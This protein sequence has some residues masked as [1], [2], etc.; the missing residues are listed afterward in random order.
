[1]NIERMYPSGGWLVTWFD[2]E[3]YLVRRR[4]YDYTKGEA[5]ALAREEQKEMTRRH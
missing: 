1:M 3:G 4:F 5:L 2:D